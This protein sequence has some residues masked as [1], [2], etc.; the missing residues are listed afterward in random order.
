M[1]KRGIFIKFRHP[2]I[3]EN[4][5][6]YT[7]NMIYSVFGVVMEWY[8]GVCLYADDV[9]VS[10]TSN[11]MDD[12]APGEV[13]NFGQKPLRLTDDTIEAK[14]EKFASRPKI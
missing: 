13:L 12:P 14:V 7:R 5:E 9:I 3:L 10:C 6:L 4:L 11:D 8:K 1:G 2:I